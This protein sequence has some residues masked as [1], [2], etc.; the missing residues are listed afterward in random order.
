MKET[1]GSERCKEWV[2]FII[3]LIDWPTMENGT[4][5]NSQAE[6]YSTTSSLRCCQALSITE[7]SMRSN[8]IGLSMKV[9]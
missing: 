2:S 3:N 6:E 9:I 8:N 7:T 4:M 1:G 5:I